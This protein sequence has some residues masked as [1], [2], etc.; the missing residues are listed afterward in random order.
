MLL[1]TIFS[2]IILSSLSI[3]WTVIIIPFIFFGYSFY[4]INDPNVITCISKNIKHS[5]I[6]DEDNEP[7]GLF[8]G[9]YYIGYKS[10]RINK[11]TPCLL[12]CLAT[13][14]TFKELTKKQY[15]GSEENKNIYISLITLKGNYYHRYSKKRDLECSNYIP[16]KNQEQVI[17][18]T[19]NYYNQNHICVTMIYGLPGT[20]KSLTALLIAKKLKGSYCKT[21]DPTIAGDSLENIYDRAQINKNNPLILLIDEFDVIL[22]KIHNNKITMHADMPTEVYNKTTWNTLLDDINIKLYPYVIIILT[23]NLSKDEIDLKYDPSYIRNK[24]VN[25]YHNLL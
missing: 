16:N 24:R 19:I 5:T 20:G 18:E 7:Y 4:N 6:R 13:Q 11:D 23:S 25:I 3:F 21:Y 15:I 10:Q 2:T 12:Y 8:I 14:Q 22:D 17:D 9:R 1:F